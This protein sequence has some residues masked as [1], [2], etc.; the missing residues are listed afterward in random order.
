[1][2]GPDYIVRAESAGQAGW[3]EACEGAGGGRNGK[4]DARR[5]TPAE[6]PKGDHR[7]YGHGGSEGT[8]AGVGP[9]ASRSAAA[10]SSATCRI[11]GTC[12]SRKAW[13]TSGGSEWTTS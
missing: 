6:G 13:L 11:E 5:S 2:S 9:R 12:N 10:S 3:E 8:P 4:G 7:R 1:M